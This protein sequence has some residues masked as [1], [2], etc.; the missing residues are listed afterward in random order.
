MLWVRAGYGLVLAAFPGWVVGLL[1]RRNPGPTGRLVV[2]TLGLREAGQAL[3]VMPRPTSAVLSVGAGVDVA[4]AGTM[5]WLAA[6]STT[7]RRPALLS[8]S[9]A[10]TYAV[11]TFVAASR[12][13][14]QTGAAPRPVAGAE[15]SPLRRLLDLRDREAL[16]VVHAVAT[17]GGLR[18]PDEE[19]R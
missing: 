17:W 11:A 14:G 5:V 4:H 1:A 15:A 18:G 16:A 2:R 3:A 13:P 19:S 8:A 10:T 12:T 7:W 6:Q 9:L